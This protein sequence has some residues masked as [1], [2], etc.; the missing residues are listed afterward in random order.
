MKLDFALHLAYK[1]GKIDC[2]AILGCDLQCDVERYGE[3]GKKVQTRMLD[4][5]ISTPDIS[6]NK[7]IDYV[8]K[9]GFKGIELSPNCSKCRDLYKT[10]PFPTQTL[11]DFADLIS[12]FVVIE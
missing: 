11:V 10:C 9:A 12:Q 4:L 7:L 3:A 1:F 5:I 2:P 8:V 6:S